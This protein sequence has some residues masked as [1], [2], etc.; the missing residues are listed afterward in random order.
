MPSKTS[1]TKQRHNWQFEALGTQWHI[2]TTQPLDVVIK[3]KITARIAVFDK[4]YSRFRH[5][6]L[7]T[8]LATAAGT[9]SFP[10]DARDLI[11]FYKQ[12]YHV[13][14]GAVSPL[15]GTMLEQAGYDKQYSLIPGQVE[16]VPVW[17]ATMTWQGSQV[18]TT[19]PVMLDFGAAGKGYMND[20]VG[21]LLEQA[22]YDAYVI[23]ASGDMRVR[24]V[25]ETIGL[26]NPYD[27]TTVIGA[28]ELTNA[29]LCASAI[30]RRA[31]ANG[32]HHIVDPRTR[33]PV[34]E[35][36]ATWVIAPTT[37]VADGLA[38]ALFFVSASALAA[39]DFE[40][41]R[42]YANGTIERSAGFVGELYV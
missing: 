3:T 20:L 26:E 21:E 17:E 41:I 13:T 9:Y 23:D 24:G 12:L 40:Y 28:V 31:W 36:V 32:W 7:V 35:I 5:D 25:R 27:S 16:P 10:D 37:I 33:R 1:K 30:N 14:G 39:W 4:T 8:R 19:Q 29:S 42:L 15:V 18:T 34:D 38:T 2:E 6:S 11:D 22:G